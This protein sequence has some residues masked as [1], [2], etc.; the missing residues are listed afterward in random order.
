MQKEMEI[1]YSQQSIL[2]GQERVFYNK[3]ILYWF[4]FQVFIY[5]LYMPILKNER[6]NKN[7]RLF[8]ASGELNWCKSVFMGYLFPKICNGV[9]SK[10]FDLEAEYKSL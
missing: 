10:W 9:D 8:P 2:N 1:P 3:V 7:S 4:A 6:C 5:L